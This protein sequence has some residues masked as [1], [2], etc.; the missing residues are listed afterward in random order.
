MNPA[1][2]TRHGSEWRCPRSDK[3]NA[4]CR[5]NTRCID[6]LTAGTALPLDVPLVMP[7]VT[8]LTANELTVVASPDVKVDARFQLECGIVAQGWKTAG[9][10]VAD[11]SAGQHRGGGVRPARRVACRRA[12]GR[13]ARRGFKPGSR[14][15]RWDRAVYRLKGSPPEQVT[16]RLPSRSAAEHRQCSTVPR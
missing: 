15:E 8:E 12:D 4:A 11:Q 13:R 7:A 9:K 1:S 16:L 2:S 3:A 6:A 14:G 5:S 10:P